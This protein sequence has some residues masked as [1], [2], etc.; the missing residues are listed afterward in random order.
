MDTQA[1]Q[2]QTKPYVEVLAEAAVVVGL[3]EAAI[4]VWSRIKTNSVIVV[5]HVST[6]VRWQ[7]HHQYPHHCVQFQCECWCMSQ[8]QLD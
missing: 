7:N 1:P 5:S 3:A 6:R 8:S 4:V 2:G